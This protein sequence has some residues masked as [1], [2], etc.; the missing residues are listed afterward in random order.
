[1]YVHVFT[2]LLSHVS[3]SRVS[4]VYDAIL[5]MEID[6]ESCD[7]MYPG[8]S[9]QD[10]DEIQGAEVP[11]DLLSFLGTLKR[12]LPHTAGIFIKH[13][14]TCDGALDWLCANVRVPEVKALGQEIKQQ[15]SLADWVHI[16]NGLCKRKGE[17]CDH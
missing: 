7:L 4:L 16:Y 13:G 6:S 10:T 11:E 12:P 17:L 3:S 9:E 2:M 15:F 14:Y 5:D 8:D 1:M